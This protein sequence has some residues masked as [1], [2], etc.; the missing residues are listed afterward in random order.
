M[1]APVLG[2]WFG[3]AE[4]RLGNGDG[5]PIVIGE[6][7]EVD[8]PLVLCERGL[9]ASEHVLDALQYAPGPMLYRVRLG[10]KTVKGDDKMCAARREYLAEIDATH[11][12]KNEET[13]LHRPIGEVRLRDKA[14][15]ENPMGERR[16]SLSR[17]P[18]RAR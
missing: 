11:G 3:T 9:H 1:T 4:R 7:H 10:G 15:A 17:N 2:W 16:P 18:S 8:P 13:Q 12:G 5:R 6:T 14:V